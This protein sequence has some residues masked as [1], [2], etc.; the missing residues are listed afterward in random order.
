MTADPTL[1]VV[2][3]AYD[4]A[5]E[6]P[7]TLASLAPAY[8]RG[9]ERADYEVIVSASGVG[10]ADIDEAARRLM[11]RDRLPRQR[12]KGGETRTYDLRPLA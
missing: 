1:S 8:Q 3:V 9:I 11:A 5:R 2:V 4:M 7:R 12:Q 6:L 10:D